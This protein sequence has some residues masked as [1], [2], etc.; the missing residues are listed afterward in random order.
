[1]LYKMSEALRN[2][3][4]GTAKSA[5]L[6]ENDVVAMFPN[7]ENGTIII[8]EWPEIVKEELYVA[9]IL[10]SLNVSHLFLTPCT[11]QFTFESEEYE[12]FSYCSPSFD[13]LT[14]TKSFYVIDVNKAIPDNLLVVAK[15]IESKS[16]NWL[17]ILSPLVKDLV[18]CL[19]HG[20]PLEEDSLNLAVCITNN[21][22]FKVVSSIHYFG[23]DFS[24]KFHRM[25]LNIE[26]RPIYTRFALYMALSRCLTH[27]ETYFSD[28][29]SVEDKILNH[30]IVAK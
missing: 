28:I 4:R 15:T 29:S 2:V 9:N 30:F 20:I 5:Y 24:H 11:I 6:F 13:S 17:Q 19:K 22:L 27:L 3:G 7:L 21:E 14:K 18:T 1:M 26:R 8:D 10:K 12:L 25:N 16:I 23:F